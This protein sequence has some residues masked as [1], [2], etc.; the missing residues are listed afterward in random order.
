MSSKCRRRPDRRPPPLTRILLPVLT[1]F[2]FEGTSQYLDDLVARIDTPLLKTLK[3][4]FFPQL[5]IDTP[6]LTHFI[7]RTPKFKTPDEARMVFSYEGLSVKLP[8]TF[9][10]VFELAISQSDL[11]IASVEEVFISFFCQALIPMVERLYILEDIL[12]RWDD[13]ENSEWLNL[14]RPFT[15]LKDLYLCSGITRHIVPALQELRLIGGRATGVLPALQTVFLAEPVPSEL[16]QETIGP[17]IAARQ[18]AS[19]PITISRWDGVRFD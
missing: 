10:G 17:F 19:P 12:W 9:D 15:A 8:R 11:P 3:I 18:L 1:S 6:Q 2:R 14:L 4:A 5:S 13:F 16:A 7:Y